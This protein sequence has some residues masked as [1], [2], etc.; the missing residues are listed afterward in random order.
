MVR[1]RAARD[2]RALK[3]FVDL[4]YR[5]HARDPLWVPPLRRDVELLLSREKNPFFEHAEAEYFLAERSGEVVGRIA[6][7][8]V[9]GYRQ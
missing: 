7:P 3:Q 1:V 9:C 8:A 2:R 5:L 6:G 4:P